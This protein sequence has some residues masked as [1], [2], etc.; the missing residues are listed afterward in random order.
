MASTE[1]VVAEHPPEVIGAI[2]DLSV[3]VSRPSKPCPPFPGKNYGTVV[4]LLFSKPMTQATVDRPSSYRLD[5]GI[6]ANSVQIQPGGRVALLN[7]REP[8]SGI[9]PRTSR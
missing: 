9:R 5:N 1:S 3:D 2:Q 7:L 8:I 4:G 6:E